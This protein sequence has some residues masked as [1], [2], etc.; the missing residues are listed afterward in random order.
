MEKVYLDN[1][2]TTRVDPNVVVVMT[3]CLR[4]NY[5]NPSSIHSFGRKSRALIEKSRRKIASLINASPSEIYFTSGGTEADNMA[6]RG[7]VRD[8]G[9]QNIIT[10][11]IEHPAV[12]N[13]AIN[14]QKQ[15]LISL[16]YVKLDDDGQVDILNLEFL[17]KKYKN[18]LVSLMHANNEIGNL[19]PIDKVSK[20]CNKH[21]ALFHSDTVQTL[22]HLPIDV[23][24]NPVDFIVCSAHKFHGPKGVGFLYVNNKINITPLIHGGSQEKNMRGGTEY[25]YGIVG[26]AKAMEIAFSKMSLHHEHIL[27]LKKHMILKLNKLLPKVKFN[28]LSGEL[29]KS[30][31]TVL[32]LSIPKF[33]NSDLLLFNLDLFGVACSGGSACSSGS[34]KLS[35]V[36]SE[37]STKEENVVVRFSFS[38]YNTIEEIDYVVDKLKYLVG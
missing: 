28:G 4:K 20:V 1:A 22:A 11:K 30:L 16:H 18:T 34:S 6:L 19:L 8:A 12:L 25:V 15:G 14:L 9:V 38:K 27:K 13:T 5:G 2:A 35:H 32:S 3:D 36:I 10:S 17:L 24:Q 7:A 33:N 23:K 31:Y 29:S 21:G 26:L 37:I